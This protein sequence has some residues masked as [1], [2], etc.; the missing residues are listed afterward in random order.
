M[1]P[2]KRGFAASPSEKAGLP[3]VAAR[4]VVYGWLTKYADTL[5]SELRDAAPS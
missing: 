2:R 1:A 4:P 5:F 3:T